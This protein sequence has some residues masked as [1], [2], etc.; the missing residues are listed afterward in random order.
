MKKVVLNIFLILF[1][2][3]VIVFGYVFV[4]TLIEENKKNKFSNN[5]DGIEVSEEIE[6]AEVEQS[7][8]VVPHKKEEKTTVKSNSNKSNDNKNVLEKT[9]DKFTNFF[10]DDENENEEEFTNDITI[11]N[12]KIKPTTKTE[13]PT[14]DKVVSPTTRNESTT[15]TTKIVS[16]SNKTETKTTNTLSTTKSTTKTTTKSTTKSSSSSTYNCSIDKYTK[17]ISNTILSRIHYISVGGSDATLIESNGHFGLVDSSNPYKD[18][19]KQDVIDNEK[20]TVNHVIKYLEKIMNCSGNGCKGKLDF[21]IATHSHSDHN[22]GMVKIANTFANKNTTYYYRK[23]VTTS[24]DFTVPEWDNMGYYTRS[25]NAFKSS[26]S[27]LEEV[28]NKKIEFTFGDYNIKLLNTE[29]ANVDESVCIKNNKIISGVGELSSSKCKDKGGKLYAYNENSNSIIELITY[30]NTKVLLAADMEYKDDLR[31]IKDEN[32][33]KLL[34][35]IDVLKFGHHGNT[36]SSH[37]NLIKV[38]KPK[39][40]II[41]RGSVSK[42]VAALSM[43]YMQKNYS[44]KIYLLGKVDDAI[45]QKFVSNG[46]YTF[47]GTHGSDVNLSDTR[48][49]GKWH[50]IEINKDE[51]EWFYFDND[52]EIK[53]TGWLKYND[54][55]YYIGSNGRAYK[56][57]QY[58][59]YNGKKSWYFFNDSCAMEKGWLKDNNKWYYLN[60]SG[61]MVTGWNKINYKNKDEWFYFNSDGVMQTGWLKENGNWYYL[62]DKGVMLTGLQTING[63]VF[64]LQSNGKMVSDTC[65]QI[66]GK[67]YCFDSN[68]YGTIK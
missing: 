39:Y 48:T 21:V 13:V 14:T 11:D 62:N 1:Y 59:S 61:A 38:L 19:T 54:K 12:D 65:M 45:V 52:E 2:L 50:L 8:D 60:S 5:Y 6:N 34:S 24:D 44:S 23:Y 22:G 64:Y 46:K 67:N 42:T 15:T 49:S 51:K 29:S 37:I 55:W 35:N 58:L 4:E 18:G 28:T 53:T 43:R 25:Y 27:C 68:G 10:S 9:I 17:K 33:K 26:G 57:W 20:Y 56:R 30:K 36:G 3:V 32:N 47:S 63:K 66:N 40:G 31:L 7:E 41:S 16:S